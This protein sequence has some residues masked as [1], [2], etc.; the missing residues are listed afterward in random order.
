[1]RCSSS[2]LIRSSPSNRWRR[3]V[4]TSTLSAFATCSSRRCDD[5][6][7]RLVHQ[8]AANSLGSRVSSEYR[9]SFDQAASLGLF[10]AQLA[11]SLKP[12]VGMRNVLIHEYVNV[13]LALVSKAIPLARDQYGQYVRSVAE[14][15]AK[16]GVPPM[17]PFTSQVGDWN[18]SNG[19][20]MMP[21]DPLSTGE[22][23]A[24]SAAE[25]DSWGWSLRYTWMHPDDGPQSGTL[26]L[27]APESDG[28]ITAA[29]LDSW[30][31]KP[32]LRLLTGTFADNTAALE[33]ECDGWF[34]R[35]SVEATADELRMLM[36]N[37]IP[38]GFEGHEPG[39]Y[40][41][42]DAHWTRPGIA[43]IQH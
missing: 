14:W 26:L 4:S 33:M 8:H 25:A 31:Q 9:D 41:V 12:S 29:W 11:E 40:V 22:S 38:D 35:I 17:N 18:G 19:F 13:D 2:S 42:M 39:P 34:W 7:P 3:S 43:A 16:Q 1:M 6:A 37:V 24:H 30:H 27:A 15:V 5:D 21:T 23:R 28:T 10:P 20:R 36:H 32:G